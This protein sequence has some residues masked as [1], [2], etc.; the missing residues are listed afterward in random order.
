MRGLDLGCTPC[1][2]ACIRAQGC[3]CCLGRPAGTW[4][5]AQSTLPLPP[6]SLFAAA[7]PCATTRW[8]RRQGKSRQAATVRRPGVLGQPPAVG[9]PAAP[10]LP[11][12]WRGLWVSRPGASLESGGAQLDARWGRHPASTVHPCHRIDAAA[13]STVDADRRPTRGCPV[14]LQA[15]RGILQIHDAMACEQSKTSSLATHC[16]RWLRV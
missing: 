14:L 9:A 3:L 13:G 7:P 2:Q 4:R 15:T 5:P 16:M 6:H 10:L 11:C 8:C 12:R 1:A